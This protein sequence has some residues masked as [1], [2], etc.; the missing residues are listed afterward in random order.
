MTSLSALAGFVDGR[1]TQ[2]VVATDNISS[3]DARSVFFNENDTLKTV[4]YGGSLVEVQGTGSD[5]PSGRR[6]WVFDS[7]AD[8]IGD[9]YLRLA[10]DVPTNPAN[11]P[12]G[13][14]LPNVTALTAIEYAVSQ[15]MGVLNLIDRIDFEVGTQIYQ[16]MYRNDIM[17]I[18]TT[19][20]S[21]GSMHKLFKNLSGGNSYPLVDT[22]N[23]KGQYIVQMEPQFN[24]QV[25]AQTGM[26]VIRSPP[27]SKTIS[28]CV[29]P[30]SMFTRNFNPIKQSRSNIN[31][32]GYYL[33]GAPDQQVRVTVH[34]SN[35]L[36]QGAPSNSQQG[37]V[38]NSMFGGSLPQ[39]AAG[40]GIF[41]NNTTGWTSQLFYRQLTLSN[42]EREAFVANKFGIPKTIKTTEGIPLPFNFENDKTRYELDLST[43]NLLGSHFI[44]SFIQANSTSNVARN[45]EDIDTH[46]IQF[47]AELLLNNTS[48]FGQ[49]P[50]S[51]LLNSEDYLGL[52]NFEPQH[53]PGQAGGGHQALGG[54]GEYVRDISTYSMLR[55]KFVIPLAST[56]YGGSMVPLN[57]F[58]NIR[59][60]L[61][62]T[63]LL[64]FS[65]GKLNESI[66]PDSPSITCA[67]TTTILYKG[68]AASLA[69]Y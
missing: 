4:L 27:N 22:Q 44:F 21:S 15:P 64:D 29:I 6:Q 43:F 65:S 46:V 66:I 54:G 45:F 69:I 38:S 61:N 50:S 28:D 39:Q 49:I 55:K 47:T 10:V 12:L 51:V 33:F 48:V 20:Q 8:V 57:R 52:E 40:A 42:T 32:S 18:M 13:Q 63:G 17:H 7:T 60:I 11:V 25:P 62:F 36:F 24:L 41:N 58:D 16:T 56:A 31:E 67:G 5:I 14:G 37:V 26:Y 35:G 59:L 53:M 23:N 19:E 9:L 3:D 1:G 68:G 34:F 30:L 2:G